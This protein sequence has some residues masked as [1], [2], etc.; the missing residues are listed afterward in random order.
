MEP[1]Q[2]MFASR[3]RQ[4]SGRERGKASA[5]PEE[6]RLPVTHEAPSHRQRSPT[7]NRRN[8]ATSGTAWSMNST[9]PGAHPLMARKPAQCSE[10]VCLDEQRRQDH[11]TRRTLTRERQTRSLVKRMNDLRQLRLDVLR[12]GSK[13]LCWISRHRANYTISCTPSFS[14]PSATDKPDGGPSTEPQI[15]DQNMDD[16]AGNARAVARFQFTRMAIPCGPNTVGSAAACR[17]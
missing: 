14:S 2:R 10:R 3:W 6:I 15:P 11:S 13:E 1:E 8:P 7:V 5:L 9:E 12:D 4:R 16:C 17:W